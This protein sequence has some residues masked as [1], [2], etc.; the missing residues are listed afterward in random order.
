[1]AAKDQPANYG[2]TATLFVL[3]TVWGGEVKALNVIV[4]GF[5]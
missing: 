4:K 5:P 3:L 1:M 2:G